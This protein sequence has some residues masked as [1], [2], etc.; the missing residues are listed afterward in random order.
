MPIGYGLLI[1]AMVATVAANVLLPLQQVAWGKRAALLSTAGIL[2][3]AAY[4]MSL[5]ATHQF[6]VAYVAEYSAEAGVVV[7]PD[8]G[9]LG[10][11]GRLHSSVGALVVGAGGCFDRARGVSGIRA[12]PIYGL[13]QIYLLALLLL[14]CP[15]KLGVGPIPTDGRGLNPLL[16]NMW[17]VIH[18]PMAVFRLVV[19]GDSG[20]SRRQ[21]TASARL[22]RLGESSV[23]LGAV[24][25][26]L[27]WLRAFARRLLGL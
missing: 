8:G 16:E 21:R 9:V 22:G 26:R 7:V 17:M 19:H 14:K 20:G 25:V 15:F 10:R 4:L 27:P 5:I 13:V 3:A 2:G 6:Q 1:F 23:S 18:P 12:W 24:F 11:A